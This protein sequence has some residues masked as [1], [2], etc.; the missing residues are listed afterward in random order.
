MQ[1][2]ETLRRQ[3]GDLTAVSFV[4]QAPDYPVIEIENDHAQASIALHGAHLMRYCRQGEAPLL[5]LSRQAIYRQG[6]AIR[7]GVP[8]CWPWFANAA[9]RPG[10][11]AHGFV[12]TRCWQVQ[13][14]R[15]LADGATEVDL[16]IEDDAQT[17]EL[18]PHA[19]HL[20]LR[21][22]IGA[23]LE[24]A[25]SM[26]NTGDTPYT[27]SGALHSYLAVTDIGS[28]TISGFDGCT[29]RDSLAAGA[30]CVQ[31]GEI[32][33]AGELDRIYIDTG[34]DALIQDAS[35]K[36][37]LRVEKTGSRTFVIWNPWIKKSAAMA[38]FEPG[39]YRQMVC[40]EAALADQDT[41][42][43]APG[44]THVLATRISG[45]PAA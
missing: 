25:L 21:L 38:D 41:I 29:Y 11:P 19:F 24:V 43:L 28:T 17:R 8:I 7:G 2:I 5:W 44:A 31:D 40:V 3:F 18:W 13:T 33:F 9:P 37:R 23:S 35:G 34:A 12:R 42:E 20:Q 45:E 14:I 16:S 15:Q 36:R 10:L 26:R 6:T 30:S 27:C 1:D 39:G 4:E 22:R 32:G